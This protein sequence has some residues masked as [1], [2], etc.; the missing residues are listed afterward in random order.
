LL[1]GDGAK[2]TVTFRFE[3]V[4]RGFVQ[5]RSLQSMYAAPNR[6]NQQFGQCR[7]FCRSKDAQTLGC[8]DTA[9]AVNVECQDTETVTDFRQLQKEEP[10]QALI[11]AGLSTSHSLG[12]LLVKFARV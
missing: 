8:R 1:F 4:T 2:R 3:K 10:R 11:R 9:Y 7:L 6:L 12:G 5:P